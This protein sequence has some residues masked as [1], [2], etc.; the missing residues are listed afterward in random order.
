[1]RH[2]TRGHIRHIRLFCLKHA[3]WQFYYEVHKATRNMQMPLVLMQARFDG[4]LGFFGGLVEE[5]ESV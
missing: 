3:P 1:M 5:D 2:A 4:K